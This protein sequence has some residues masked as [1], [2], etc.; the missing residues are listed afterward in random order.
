MPDSFIQTLRTTSHLITECEGCKVV[1]PLAFHRVGYTMRG[2][3][4]HA[5]PVPTTKSDSASLSGRP[6]LAQVGADVFASHD[7]AVLA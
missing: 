1:E 5:T 3:F 2:A 6:S 7:G 4:V